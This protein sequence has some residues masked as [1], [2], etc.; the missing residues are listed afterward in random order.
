MYYL[1]SLIFPPVSLLFQGR[2]FHFIFNCFLILLSFLNIFT[3]PFVM[4]FP[5]IHALLV[6]VSYYRK[7]KE[8]QIIKQ[9]DEDIKRELSELKELLKHK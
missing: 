4:L 2:F 6:T 8:Q 3:I 1:L 7:Q 9:R 5:S